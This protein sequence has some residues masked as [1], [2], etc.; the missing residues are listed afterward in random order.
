MS[1]LRKPIWTDRQRAKYWRQWMRAIA[2]MKPDPEYRGRCF[3]CRRM[4]IMFDGIQMRG[5]VMRP[6]FLLCDKCY[7]GDN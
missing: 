3:K 4:F 5:L 2:G 7:E 1:S 6:R